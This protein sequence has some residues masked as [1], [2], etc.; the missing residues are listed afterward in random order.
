MYKLV[1]NTGEIRDVF[2]LFSHNF[3]KSAIAHMTDTT[4]I[5]CLPSWGF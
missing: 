5:M 3:K 2:S 4:N 1:L